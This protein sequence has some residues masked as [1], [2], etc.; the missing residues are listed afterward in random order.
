MRTLNQQCDEKWQVFLS[1]LKEV[2]KNEK[3]FMKIFGH[4]HPSEVDKIMFKQGFLL[5]AATAYSNVSK[6]QKGQIKDVPTWHMEGG[7][8]GD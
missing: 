3:W 6:F 1:K 5:G 4:E 8:N 7:K 2:R